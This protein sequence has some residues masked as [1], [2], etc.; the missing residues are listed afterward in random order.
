MADQAFDFSFSIPQP[1]TGPV[2]ALSA[3]E[4]ENMLL[5]RL[6]KSKSDP[7]DA[8]RQLAM[9]YVRSGQHDK[10]LARFRQLLE[11]LANLEDKAACVLNMGATMESVGDFEG[12][13]RYYKE[14]SALEPA[15]TSTWYLIHNNLGFSLNK[16][17]R[18]AEGEAYCREAIKIDA[19]RHNAFKNLG[20][21]LVGQGEHREAARCFVT[22]TQVDAAD[23]RAFHLL[24]DL[25][26]Q[27]PELEYEFQDAI[28]SCHEVIEYVKTQ[29]PNIEPVVYRGWRKR[30]TL[31]RWKLASVFRRFKVPRKIAPAPFTSSGESHGKQGGE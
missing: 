16:L 14:A 17:G 18:F 19:N 23:D 3:E 6:E 31:L 21:S 4:A 27:H 5:Q 25:I 26:A 11:R 1:P 12:A 7:T 10:A 9:F 30:V 28:A 8:L 29:N 20:I 2:V 13:V 22:A 15:Q 24:E